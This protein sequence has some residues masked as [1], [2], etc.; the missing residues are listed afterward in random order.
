M[1][2]VKTFFFAAFF[3]GMAGWCTAQDA[4]PN[5]SFSKAKSFEKANEVFQVSCMQCHSAQTPVPWY[6]RLPVVSSAM[7]K[8]YRSALKELNLDNEVYLPGI[9][10]APETLDKIESVIQK[11]SMPPLYF[12]MRHWK[13]RL[14][15]KDKQAIL[16][17]ISDERRAQQPPAQTI[18]AASH[19]PPTPDLKPLKV[20][21]ASFIQLDS[22][23]EAPVVESV[24]AEEEDHSNP[25]KPRKF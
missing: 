23:D 19:L 13:S 21:E 14:S 10:I 17:W 5:S 20:I 24:P 3:F 15:K 8:E 11:G 12:R 16:D 1:R 22:E 4:S 7:K 25:F 18:V 2:S 9:K 6:G